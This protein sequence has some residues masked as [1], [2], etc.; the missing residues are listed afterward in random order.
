MG[1]RPY[2]EAVHQ[3]E[4]RIVPQSGSSG[5]PLDGPS[6][7][8]MHSWWHPVKQ[9]KLDREGPAKFWEETL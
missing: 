1:K 5:L 9:K 7:F 2:I 8:K 4:Q 6:S 3:S